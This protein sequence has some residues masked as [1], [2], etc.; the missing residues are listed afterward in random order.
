METNHSWKSIF[1]GLLSV[2]TIAPVTDG[3]SQSV[4]KKSSESEE[5]TANPNSVPYS[6]ERSAGEHLL[7]LPSYLLHWTTRP[8]GW[9]VKWAERELPHLLQGERAPYGVYPLFELGGDVG[10]AYGLLLYHNQFTSYN[11]R[12]RIEALFGSQEYNDVDFKYAIPQFFSSR[13]Q[14]EFDASYS[15]D[16]VKSLYGGN[17][18]ALVNEQ[19]YATEELEGGIEFRH[20]VSPATTLTISGRYRKMDISNNEIV[21]EDP[22]PLIPEPLRGATA[23]LGIGSSLQFDFVNESPRSTHGARYILGLNWNRSLTDDRFHYLTYQLEWHQFLPVPFLPDTRRLALKTR[24]QK[25]APLGDREI[26]FFDYPI[27]GSSNDLRGFPTDRFRDDGS[28]LATLEYR[29]PLWNFADIVLF[30]DEGQVFNGYSDIGLEDFH[31]SYGFGLHLIS[32]KG[33]AFRSEFAFSKESSRVILSINPN[34]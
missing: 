18:S 26:P 11:H 7:A 14:L 5:A 8:L 6:S 22:L 31:T 17:N 3:W 29:Y 33:F 16:P 25:T 23:L 9:G 32:T 21:R 1:V 19:L 27:L 15:N 2:L 34:F 24:V 20:L 28:L 13:S 12:A 4:Q 30:V 10:I